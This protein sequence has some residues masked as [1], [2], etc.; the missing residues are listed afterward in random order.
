MILLLRL[1]YQH[2]WLYIL[3]DTSINFSVLNITVMLA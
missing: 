1:D 2:T 3:V